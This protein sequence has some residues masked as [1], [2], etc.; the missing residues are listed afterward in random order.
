MHKIH[1]IGHVYI[2]RIANH[3]S[4]LLWLIGLVPPRGRAQASKKNYTLLP[5]LW[6]ECWRMLKPSLHAHSVHPEFTP[7]S[8]YTHP[9][10]VDEKQL[11]IEKK[12]ELTSTLPT[13]PKAYPILRIPILQ[14]LPKRSS[15]LMTRSPSSGAYRE[16]HG[17]VEQLRTTATTTSKLSSCRTW[18]G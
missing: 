7:H 6:I 16:D 14:I 11:A 4:L 8:A 13:A 3:K 10:H 2:S 18:K 9:A 1:L 15:P 5:P 17:K 12:H